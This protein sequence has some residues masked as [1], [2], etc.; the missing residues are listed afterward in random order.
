MNINKYGI[1]NMYLKQTFLMIALGAMAMTAAAQDAQPV[2]STAPQTYRA[3][4]P[5]DLAAKRTE[6]LA[7]KAEA[8]KQ[9]MDGEIDA[10]KY[11]DEEFRIS[12]ELEG[13][14][15]ARARAET[16]AEV[17]RQTAEVYQGNV[18]SALVARTKTEIDYASDTDAQQTF[19]RALRLVASEPDAAGRDFAQIADEA[20]RMVM[21]RRGVAPAAPSTAGRAAPDRT[22]PKPPIT[23][24]GLPTAAASGTKSIS[25]VA[26]RLTG[27]DL[28]QAFDALPDADLK[29]LMRG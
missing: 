11:A 14:T 8:M 26:G 28:E 7:A 6:L 15:L 29:K 23:L 5:A 3:D 19:D 12:E 24:G 21:A 1:N 4:M 18:I 20:H 9:L 17:N 22:P 10:E 13:I 27:D 2:A 16:L 25:E